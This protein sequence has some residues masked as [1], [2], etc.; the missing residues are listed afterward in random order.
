MINPD[1][2]SALT[3]SAAACGGAVHGEDT[4]SNTNGDRCNWLTRSV[5]TVRACSLLVPPGAVT[6]IIICWP[7]C[8]NLSP[9]T[10]M[11]CADSEVGS[12][13]PPGDRLLATGTPKTAA[14]MN[15]RTPTATIRR[16]AAMAIRAILCSMWES[17]RR[18]C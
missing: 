10:S 12:W 2:P 16:G 8:P 4:L 7:L 6:T 9:S 5:P 13:K 18:G 1:L 11:A 15:T 14:A 3:R 17:F